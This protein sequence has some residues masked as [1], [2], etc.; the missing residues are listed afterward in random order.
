MRTAV[1]GAVLALCV[2]A[3]L[4]GLYHFGLGSKLFSLKTEPSIQLSVENRTLI[5]KPIMI[6]EL[7]KNL[8]D[9]PAEGMIVEPDGRVPVILY[10]E[11]TRISPDSSAAEITALGESLSTEDALPHVKLN[12][13]AWDENPESSIAVLNDRIVHE[14]DFLGDVRVLRIK[15]NHVVLLHGDEH[16]IKKIHKEDKEQGPETG[17]ME[18]KGEEEN[19]TA[20]EDSSFTDYSPIVNFDYRASKMAP[21]SYE[22]LDR[23]ATIAKL[24]PDCEI[25]IRGY[26]DSVGS[27]K[28]NQRLSMERA[29]IV[30]GYLVEKGV[31]PEKIET[32]G[33]GETDPIVPNDTL[34]GRAANRRVEIELVLV[35]DN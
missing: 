6:P 32:I 21:G 1:A 26:T 24:S 12:A 13:I 5:R 35:D 31:S 25:V 9:E 23:L 33:M 15:P 2:S 19:T 3:A 30:A 7:A 34:E 4:V 11:A 14:G 28:F 22:K 29:K 17:A 8:A 18:T 20:Q 16:V 27:Y 10:G